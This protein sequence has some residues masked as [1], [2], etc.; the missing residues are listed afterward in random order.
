MYHPFL[1]ATLRKPEKQI[2]L[3][4]KCYESTYSRADII[5]ANA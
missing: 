2:N 1:N 4:F 3:R 5:F